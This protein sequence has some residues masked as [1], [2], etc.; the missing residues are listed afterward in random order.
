[1]SKIEKSGSV[2]DNRLKTIA[3]STNFRWWF[4]VALW[5]LLLISYIDRT[6][7][8]I[9]GP[10]MVSHGVVTVAALAL[11]NSLFL[12]MYGLSNIFGGYLSDKYG[13]QKI[14]LI[15][16]TWWS[17]MTLFCGFVWSS[18]S[19]VF[20]RVLLGLGEGMHWPLNSKWVKAWFPAHERA[21]ANMFWNF[22]LSMGPIITGPLV[23]WM[24]LA[25]GTWSTPFIVF[26]LLGLIIMVPLIL[27]VAKDRPE[28]SRFVSKDELTYIQ[29][30]KTEEVAETV[31]MSQVFRKSDFWL[32]LINWSGMATIFY[33]ILFWLPSY[34]INVRHLSV[35][36][37]G[38]WYMMPY[39]LMTLCIIA[40]SFLSDKI[41]KRAIFSAIGT[42]IA[43]L[44]LLI[45]THV[46]N[47]VL[48]MTLISISS[49]MNGVILPTVWSSL[50]RMF[51]SKSVGA[52]A[53]MLNGLENII[54]AV[55]TFIL[56]ISFTVGFSYLIIFALIGGLS[57]LVLA[58]KGY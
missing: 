5:F 57:G 21:R 51:P 14:A 53:G 9:A 41:M 33:G 28:E 35:S 47:I 24:I 30:D 56:G 32:L 39:I 26:A 58:R 8:S 45:G 42:L 6:N 36:M 52:G 19:L 37:T 48:A 29:S 43:G 11:G 54:S 7:I 12:I 25:S 40:T 17:L 27:I 44:G 55:G 2:Y 18:L 1:M 10:V 49:A 13:P 50:Q 23:T 34:L 22:G 31:K 20:S 46:G 15:A 16:L 38:F 4:A 3:S